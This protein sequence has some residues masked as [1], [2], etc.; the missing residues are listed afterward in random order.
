MDG[1][2]LVKLAERKL[3]DLTERH[4]YFMSQGDEL[5]AS[6]IADEGLLLAE[7]LENN[8]TFYCLPILED[9]GPFGLDVQGV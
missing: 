3:G 4:D 7:A 6:F 2:T 8:H 9:M 5:S 1:E